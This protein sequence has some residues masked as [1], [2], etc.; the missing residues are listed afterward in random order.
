M[1]N[2]SFTQARLAA[3]YSFKLRVIGALVRQSWVVIGESVGTT[4]HVKRIALAH[5]ILSN[6]EAYATTLLPVL[7]MRTNVFAFATSYD[8]R[9]GSVVTAAGDPDI[10]NQIFNDWENL[11][12]F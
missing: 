7:V 8:F 10:E 12:G 9:A 1:A 11:P 6:V 5:L 4:N 2:D 3:D